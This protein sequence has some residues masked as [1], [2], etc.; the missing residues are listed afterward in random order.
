MRLADSK[1]AARLLVAQTLLESLQGYP[2]IK[3]PELDLETKSNI[4]LYKQQL[5]NE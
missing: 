5:Q 3:E 4:E 2:D 1:P